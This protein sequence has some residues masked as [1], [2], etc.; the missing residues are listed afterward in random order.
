M[1]RIFFPLLALPLLTAAAPPPAV[2]A[3]TAADVRWNAGTYDV[4]W[5]TARPGAPVDVYVSADPVAAP[6]AMKK[7][8]DN[9]TDGAESFREPLGPGV[10]PYFYVK[11]DG[12]RTGVRIATRVIPLAGASNFRDVGGYPT[13]DGHRVKWG[14]VFRSNALSDLTA[15][16]YKTVDGLGLRLICD[17]RTDQERTAQPT[18]W[19]GRPPAF[20]NSPK[21]NLDFDAKSLMGEG[22]PTAETVRENFIAFY[23][24]TPKVYAPEY[25]A[26]FA[27]LK[28]GDAP[29][30]VH[31]TAGKDRTGVGSALILTAL[32]V[33]RSII[34]SDYAMSEKYQQSTM[35]QQAAR[36]DDPATALLAKLPPEVLMVLMR[37]E[38]AYIEAALDALT[39]EYGSVEA[40]LDKELGV[41]AADLAALR[42]RYTE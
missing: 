29:M 40:F 3:V 34:V 6:K 15:A 9:D 13:T 28:A 12:A 27:R 32:G 42:K 25:K 38:P 24:Q 1:K 23:R 18:M 16:D 19:Q 30:L 10:R 26:M 33:P 22:T 35:R 39:A 7:L 20:L 14:Q 31:C 8:A 41:S 21:A 17:L 4:S 36:A 2:T 37:T 11:A 5:T